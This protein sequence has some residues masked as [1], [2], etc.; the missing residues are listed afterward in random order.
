LR[1]LRNK[2]RLVILR[3]VDYEERASISIKGFNVLAFISVIFLVMFFVFYLLFG[4]T[5]FKSLLPGTFTSVKQQKVVR[6]AYKADS[7][8]RLM[9]AQKAYLNNVQA[10]L[11]GDVADSPRLRKTARK[12][13]EEVQQ[14]S[15]NLKTNSMQDS[16]FR[17]EF[18][19]Q[20]PYQ[21]AF[22]EA[23][24]PRQGLADYAFFPPLKGEITSR[25]NES[26]GHFAVDIV[27]PENVGIKAVL[28]GTVIFS[29]WSA[30]TGHVIM[31]QHAHNLVSVY[32]HNS[33]LLKKV[34]KFVGAGEVI[35]IIGESGE[36]S[37]GPHLHFELWHK[38]NPINPEEY[39]AF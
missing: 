6:L 27:G 15:V 2:Y 30:A 7:L 14:D 32:K 17:A 31:V 38:G 5:P 10:I 29:E 19:S 25:Y 24:K 36:L 33:E 4:F 28:D 39:I 35:A 1:R 8:S 9:K 3:D 20:D 22:N 12:E 37:T 18:E 11:K 23:G 34:G 13:L 16:L 21:I 26:S